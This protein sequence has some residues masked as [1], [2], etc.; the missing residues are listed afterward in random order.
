[1]RSAPSSTPFPLSLRVIALIVLLATAVALLGGTSARATGDVTITASQN[2]TPVASSDSQGDFSLGLSA[3]NNSG[4]PVNDSAKLT[5]NLP[6]GVTPALSAN[7]T[8][9]GPYVCPISL[10]LGATDSNVALPDLAL[11]A[12]P[13]GVTGSGLT[14]SGM[15]DTNN[16]AIDVPNYDI[17]V[18]QQADVG[19]DNTVFAVPASSV[20]SPDSG[21]GAVAGEG[22]KYV[23]TVTNHGPSDASNVVVTDTVDSALVPS[24]VQV[25]PGGTNCAPAT[26]G[27]GGVI[28]FHTLASLAPNAP[29]SWTI[30]GT[31]DA[32]A[33]NNSTL[34]NNAAETSDTPDPGP[35][36]NSA[37]APATV[38]RKA[39]LG[40]T[41]TVTAVPSTGIYAPGSGFGAVAGQGVKYLITVT[42]HGP[43]QT[44]AVS[45]T[46]Q[47]DS[48]IDA[49]SVQVC[50]SNGAN[51]QAATVAND[52]TFSVAT[53]LSL[54]ATGVTASQSFVVT[55]TVNHSAPHGDTLANLASVSSSDST[56]QGP[57]A[58]KAERDVA[59]QTRANLTVT[60]MIAS[61]QA[62]LNANNNFAMNV[63]TLTLNFQNNGPSDSQGVVITSPPPGAST[64]PAFTFSPTSS[65]E[66]DGGGGTGQVVI[67]AHA[68]PLLGHAPPSTIVSGPFLV[69]DSLKVEPA[70][71]T[72]EADDS[73]N[74]EPN[75]LS[76]GITVNTAPS[77]PQNPSTANGNTNVV[78]SWK[79]PA[80][81]GTHTPPYTGSNPFTLDPTTPYRI[82]VYTGTQ[83]NGLTRIRQ[84]PVSASAAQP[85]LGNTAGVC[86]NVGIGATGTQNAP[87]PNGVTYTFG[88][89]AQNS[90]DWSDEAR[91]SH[92][93]LPTAKPTIDAQAT[94][95]PPA[96]AQTLTTCK[97]ATRSQPVCVQ[98]VVP[99]GGGGV[100]GV[101]GK[102]GCGLDV[103]CVGN[104]AFDLISAAYS[105]TTP[106][107]NKPITE[108][109]TWDSDPLSGQGGPFTLSPLPAIF[110]QS[111]SPA[112]PLFDTTRYPNGAGGQPF[113]LA[114]CL[115]G[116]VAKP[117]PCWTSMNLLGS[118]T[119]PDKNAQG[120]LQVQVLLTSDVD[121]LTSKH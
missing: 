4:S 86:F 47:V 87:L 117:D 57:T 115:K 21:F 88:I 20:L 37:D 73:D 36:P 26:I 35:T 66:I 103:S 72:V 95:I 82:N 97:T 40:V 11:H 50:D 101:Q 85:C 58:N 79:A 110:Y 28:T 14:G 18:D 69:R 104:A 23:V 56:D 9:A 109:V 65:G 8:G 3:T 32:S 25:C 10:N 91:D 29:A 34:T 74:V 121:G 55:A 15:T 118:K 1:V 102:V 64:I 94:I 93:N 16:Q 41:N 24:T 51:C 106:N 45:V 71:P 53:G 89:Q 111:Q 59:I 39:D 113:Q 33:S 5:L 63:V 12:D 22:V 43:S 52:G 120:D 119:N 105:G 98:Y 81:D 17:T 31:V 42:N 116:G 62:T 96:T 19:V 107:I 77:P 90:V 44:D 60:S 54:T 75:A 70:L 49:S 108:I 13:S 61:S 114:K 27:A 46:D 2:G 48:H 112:A 83:P 84:I 30:T 67:T 7:C 80:F 68:N 76:P 100:A 99:S 6:T 38:Q 78:V 92:G